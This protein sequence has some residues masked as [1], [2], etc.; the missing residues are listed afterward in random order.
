[1][2]V[3]VYMCIYIYIYI[4]VYIYVYIHIHVYIYIYIY[5]YIYTHI[6]V[7][8]YIK[9][10]VHCTLESIGRALTVKLRWLKVSIASHIMRA[11]VSKTSP[12]TMNPQ[13]Y[14]F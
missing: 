12:Q 9:S 1:M 8:R 5:V 3:C 13:T 6:Y 4:H 14:N 10:W 11:S 7:Y 2:Y